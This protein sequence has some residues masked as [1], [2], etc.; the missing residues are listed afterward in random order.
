MAP[1]KGEGP[2]SVAADHEALDTE[3]TRPVTNKPFPH[4]NQ[5][6]LSWGDVN[7]LTK[8]RFGKIDVPCPFCSAGRKPANRRKPCFRIWRTA[9]DFATFHCA[10]CQEH[11]FVFPDRPSRPVNRSERR[12]QQAEASRRDRNDQLKRQAAAIRLGDSRQRFFGSPA[13]TYLRITRELGDYLDGFDLDQVLGFIPNCPF[14]KER[15]PCLVGLVR[16]IATDEVIGIHRTALTN[17]VR[18]QRI[19]RLSLGSVGSGAIKLSPDEEVTT[20]LLVGE[21]VETV[22]SASKKF[23]FRPVWSVISRSGI[24]KFPI[25]RGMESMT[26]AV[27]RDESGDGQ[28]DAATLAQRLEDAG[29]EAIRV[30]PKIGKDFNDVLRGAA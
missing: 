7:T 2:G 15:A 20:S 23:Q 14:R 10:H 11:G 12:R 1:S 9:G 24:A 29:I 3:T 13:D 30:T 17:E 22:L 26:I 5:Q 18:P 6:A 21:G 25:L 27:D 4:R 16:D 8:G 19:D 28:R